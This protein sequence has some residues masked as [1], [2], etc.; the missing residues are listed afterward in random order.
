MGTIH[1]LVSPLCKASAQFPNLKEVSM[2]LSSW[3]LGMFSHSAAYLDAVSQAKVPFA[4]EAK[5]LSEPSLRSVKSA[6][7]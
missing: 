5:C 6:L 1:F 3:A 2:S 4:Q 7:R